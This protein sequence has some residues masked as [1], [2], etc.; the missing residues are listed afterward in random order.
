MSDETPVL[1]TPKGKK[2]FNKASYDQGYRQG[3]AKGRRKGLVEAHEAINKSTLTDQQKK[4]VLAILPA[5]PVDR[6]MTPEKK[7]AKKAKLEK[8]LEALK[9]K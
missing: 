3:S 2:D 9:E 7:A 8:Q 1:P 4:I 5:I 6:T